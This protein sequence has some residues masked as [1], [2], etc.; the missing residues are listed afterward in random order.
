MQDCFTKEALMLNSARHHKR[1]KDKR[2][3]AAMI[4]KAL[5]C[6]G[7]LYACS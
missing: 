2:R 7:L 1:L 4:E 6:A 3:E 5:A